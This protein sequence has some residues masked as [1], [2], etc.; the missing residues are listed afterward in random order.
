M[1][2][3]FTRCPPWDHPRACGEHPAMPFHVFW[4]PGSS[5]R[6]RGTPFQCAYDCTSG[7]IIPALAGNTGSTMLQTAGCRDH[8]RACGE[9][10]NAFINPACVTGSSPR[11]RGTHHVS[12]VQFPRI[13]IIPALAGNTRYAT[14]S[15]PP[16]WD[17]P[18]ACGEH[19][20]AVTVG[21]RYRGSSPRLRG[22]PDIHIHDIEQ[23]GIIPAL[24]GNTSDDAVNFLD[25]RDHPRACGEHMGPCKLA[26][27]ETGSSPRL[28][29]TPPHWT[30]R[31]TGTGIIPALAGNT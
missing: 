27:P 28:R 3:S 19:P 22:T 23:A 13:G 8:P 31:T 25:G 6:L 17:H 26:P 24:A 20:V 11:L 29:G 21:S 18:R 30:T 9:H 10:S 2:T 1:S 15:R 4:M 14:C 5:P 12:R 16:R 7:G